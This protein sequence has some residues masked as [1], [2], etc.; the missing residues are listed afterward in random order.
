MRWKPSLRFARRLFFALSCVLLT[1][2]LAAA[3]A[4]PGPQHLLCPTCQ[5]LDKIA[6]K[7]YVDP[8]ISAPERKKIA[9]ALERAR[10]RVAAFFG[11]LRSSPRI[12]VCRSRAC[13]RAFGTRGAKGVAYAWHAILLTNSRIF[14]VIAAHE[15][16][17]IEL[18]WRMGLS[19][20]LR[21]TVP[22]WFDEGL[23]TLVSEDPR[24]KRDA[25]AAAVRDI[26]SVQ[27]YLGHWAQYTG[28][29]GWRAAYGAA[30]TRVRQLERRIG[31]DG[32]R[33]FVDRLAR[34]GDLAGLLQRVDRGQSI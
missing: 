17:H 18:H 23:A 14:T 9:T 21:G 11:E 25:S 8:V 6:D 3:V 34:D 22:A 5:G 15:L 10:G 13:A 24:F 32:L 26:M 7:I 28:R 27:S 1:A 16:A 19:G 2:G 4:L 29:V 12:V 30:R 20:W 33:R 31:R